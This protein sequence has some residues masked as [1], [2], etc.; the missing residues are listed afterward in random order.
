MSMR[1]L[2]SLVLL[3]VLIAIFVALIMADRWRTNATGG[4]VR[5]R[6]ARRIESWSS[7]PNR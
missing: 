4:A 1:V 7:G 3:I 2:V 6:A 5:G